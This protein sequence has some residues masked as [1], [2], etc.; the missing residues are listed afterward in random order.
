MFEKIH[1]IYTIY[2]HSNCQSKQFMC[3]LLLLLPDMT[4]YF[5]SLAPSAGSAASAGAT[6]TAG[7][8]TAASDT[9]PTPVEAM[10]AAAT[11]SITTMECDSSLSARRLSLEGQTYV[12]QVRCFFY[13]VYLW[14]V[15][16]M[17]CLFYMSCSSMSCLASSGEVLILWVVYPWTV[18]SMS[19]LF[20]ELFFYEWFIA[21]LFIHELFSYEVNICKNNN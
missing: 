7:A 9:I 8:T 1:L 20:N 21:K 6:A 4:P 13:V 15:D 14:A 12:S 2:F 16:S 18:Y 19:F 17:S 3:L 5:E 11:I 10:D